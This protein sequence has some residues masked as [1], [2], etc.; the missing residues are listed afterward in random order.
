M[1]RAHLGHTTG[2][3]RDDDESA[4]VR[5]HRHRLCRRDR[6][7][8]TGHERPV[9]RADPARRQPRQ[10]RRRGGRHQPRRL[11]R[12][13]LRR[14]R[15]RLPGPQGLRPGHPGRRRQPKAGR[16]PHRSAAPQRGHLAGHPGRPHVGR[17]RLHPAGRLQPGRSVDLSVPKAVRP[18]RLPG[19]RHGHR[20][21]HRPPQIP[22]RS[23]FAGGQPQRARLHHRRARAWTCPT[24]AG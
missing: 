23:V 3:W 12:P 20:A 5:G 9:F 10:G 7:L 11:V 13:A 24:T 16:D 14:P 2:N 18:A 21:G 8:H 1:M 17:A 6:R 4:K 15:R 22:G 19:H